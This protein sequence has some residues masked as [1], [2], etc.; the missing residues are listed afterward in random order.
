VMVNK[1]FNIAMHGRA[2]CTGKAWRR[3][4]GGSAI[5]RPCLRPFLGD[6]SPRN[7][8]MS[9]GAIHPISRSH[10]P[11]ERKGGPIL[12]PSCKPFAYSILHR[13]SL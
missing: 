2:C 9:H 12:S 8:H 5:P 1:G 3:S 6:P 11:Q 4:R 13:I 7:V 10:R